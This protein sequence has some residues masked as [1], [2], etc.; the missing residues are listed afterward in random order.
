MGPGNHIGDLRLTTGERRAES[1]TAQDDCVL[2]SL[3]REAISAGLTGLLDRT[4]TERRIVAS[5][6]RDG[7]ATPDEL[8][9][10][11]SD[12]DLTQLNSAISMLLNDGALRQSG[13]ALSV[14]QKRS[15]KAGS[16]D[17]LDRL[18]DF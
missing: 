5:I 16:R 4:P 1:A 9:T 14:V 18:G 11:L 3:S 10:R 17:L 6:L 2:R 7:S 13:E 15:V 8:T 12:I